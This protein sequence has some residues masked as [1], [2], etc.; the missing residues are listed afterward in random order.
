MF[1]LQNSMTTSFLKEYLSC[2]TFLVAVGQL[3]GG[4]GDMQQTAHMGNS[5]MLTVSEGVPPA[6]PHNL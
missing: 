6:F 2:Y 4:R 3:S 5:S 1:L